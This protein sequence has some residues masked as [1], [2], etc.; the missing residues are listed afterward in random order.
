VTIDSVRPN[1]SAREAGTK[2]AIMIWLPAV[3][4][5]TGSFRRITLAVLAGLTLA[6]ATGCGAQS[7]SDSGGGGSAQ[8]GSAQSS[9]D[10]GFPASTRVNKYGQ[11]TITGA[12]NASSGFPVA[13]WS[14]FP[15][16]INVA[17][18]FE[19]LCEVTIHVPHNTQPG[20]YPM[21][22]NV[23]ND[24]HS[25][26]A[27]YG[28]TCHGAT[29]FTSQSGTLTLTSTSATWSG[30]FDFTAVGTSDSSKTIHVSGSF[31]DVPK[32]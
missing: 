27:G 10:S 13:Q 1:A 25:V 14:D 26:S 22:D 4:S 3:A 11:V 28:D 12:V 31:K 24:G 7:S 20:T 5:V 16:D 30:T 32:V 23:T 15:G 21:V 9:S 29:D 19:V 2:E 6:G 17:L 18:T 8:G